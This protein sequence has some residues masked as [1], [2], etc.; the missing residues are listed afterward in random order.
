MQLGEILSKRDGFSIVSYRTNSGNNI[1]SSSFIETESDNRK[2]RVEPYGLCVTSNGTVY[3]KRGGTLKQHLS[4]SGYMHVPYHKREGVT[5][6]S[7]TVTVHRLVALAFVPNPDNKPSI[8]HI[9][10]NR[11]NNRASNLE[12][13]TARENIVHAR[14]VLG[15]SIGRKKVKTELPDSI[16]SLITGSDYW[17]RAKSNRYKKL[18]REGNLHKLLKLAEVART[19]DNPANWFA[20][21]CS[22]KCWERT[23]DF[24]SKLHEVSQKAADIAKRVFARPEQMKAIYKACWRSKDALRHAITAEETGRDKFKYFC[25]LVWKGKEGG[26]GAA[27]TR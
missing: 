16:S 18:V 17:V 4:T 26:N 2:I 13:V 14:D 12:W 23:L 8:N 15:V 20:K 7:T 25:W 1:T 6:K 10:G 9:D 11:Q 5:Y 3:G 21:A 19:K 24:L 22:V 27:Y